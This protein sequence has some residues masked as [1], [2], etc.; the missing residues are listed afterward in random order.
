VFEIIEECFFDKKTGDLIVSFGLIPGIVKIIRYFN[1]HFRENR[2]GSWNNW[3][4]END[5]YKYL[6]NLILRVSFIGAF[7]VLP[8]NSSHFLFSKNE[9]IMK[10]N[11]IECNSKLFKSLLNDYSDYFLKFNGI[12]G[13]VEFVSYFN[14]QSLFLFLFLFFFFIIFF[15]FF[16]E[17]VEI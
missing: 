1:S 5:F 11:V 4:F 10:N 14:G 13:I 7:N 17:F 8:L 9:V 16:R 6:S 2:N 15:F 3:N 12:E